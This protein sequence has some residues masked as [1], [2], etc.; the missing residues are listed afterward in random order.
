MADK[1]RFNCNT[2]ISMFNKGGYE[3]YVALINHNSTKNC[4]EM[5]AK[6]YFD[7]WVAQFIT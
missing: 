6:L 1:M 2:E 3:A 7:D 5:Q 4:K